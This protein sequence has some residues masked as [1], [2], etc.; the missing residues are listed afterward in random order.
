MPNRITRHCR[1]L[2]FFFL[3]AAISAPV[4]AQLEEIV[5]TAKK[6]EQS[7]QDI[8]ISIAAVDER[9]FR[10]INGSDIE[11]LAGQISNVQAYGGGTF[12]QT[13]YIRGVGLN[14]FQ[15]NFDAPVGLHVDEVYQSKPWMTSLPYFDIERVELLKGPQG[16]IFG[17]NTTGGA[18]NYYTNK[19]SDE[20]SYGIDL[21]ANEHERY[22]VQGFI[23][24]ALG[25]DL[26]GR[27][28]FYTGLGNG[29]PYHNLFDGADVGKWDRNMFRGQLQWQNETTMVR[30]SVHGGRDQS[31]DVPYGGPGIFSRTG[32]G[33]CPEV[34]NGS[35]TNNRSACFKFAGLVGTDVA[36]GE[37]EPADPFTI[38]QD[39]PGAR[40]DKFYGGYLR[41]EHDIGWATVSSITA[42]EYFD[43][44]QR[45]DSSADAFAATNTNWYNNMQQISQELRLTGDYGD[46]WN[47]TIGGYYESDD[48]EEVDGSDLSGN[49][50]GIA[51]P[52]ATYFFADF[53][54][55]LDSFAAFF[56]AEYEF[57][58]QITVTGGVRYTHDTTKVNGLTALGLNDPVGKEDRVTPCL[59]T[60]F[61]ATPVATPA[62]PFLGPLAPNGGRYIAERK[63]DD[64]SW[65]VG[66]QW[67]PMD[68][69]MAYVNLS[70]GFRAGN[71]SVPFAGIATTFAPEEIFA[72]EVGVKTQLLD[73]TL[74]VTA[75]FFRYEYENLQV[76]VDDPVSQLVPITRNIGESETLGFEADLWWAPNDNWDVK[77]GIGYLD[78]EFKETDRSVSTYLGPIPL[79]GKRPV[80]TPEWQLNG[81]IRYERPAMDGWNLILMTDFY[82]VD[83]RFLEV[84][85]QVFDAAD[86]Y[87]IAN[88]RGA[89]ASQDGKWEVAV[90][91]RN[92][93]D[94][95][96]LTYINNIAFFKLD[97]FGEPATFGGSVS[98]RFE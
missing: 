62:C 26:T 67:E 35:V 94:K 16:T 15:G 2:A 41:I 47:Y 88:V 29:G 79:E 96:Y 69:V 58:E 90:W 49:P 8:G 83:D 18:V 38:N 70:T 91:G 32:P 42:Y 51:P 36:S 75:A 57:N 23:N 98:Y 13:F 61:A 85:N 17:R 78:A 73:D 68:N 74:R 80:N 82:W 53:T 52:F 12:L 22:S 9:T 40:D 97:I 46:K 1:L 71:F 33:L 6:R 50:L 43:R 7:V 20:F 66:V 37:V 39:R 45:E 28:S 24:G 27:F 93:F 56:D 25:E 92:V 63:D 5:V 10:E 34:L 64:I 48:L 31:D 60:T 54:N 76:N 81:L 59:I 87:F 30:L 19:P 3:C 21:S 4:F 72:Q 84:T 65:R 77:G 86:D 95:E 14:E 55:K 11:T 44:N 89:L